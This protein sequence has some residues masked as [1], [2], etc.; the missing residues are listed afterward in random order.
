MVIAGVG[1]QGILSIAAVLGRAALG[2]GLRV[3][4]S[5]VH[6]MA[7][8]GGAVVS[9]FRIADA[10]IHSDVIPRGGA[11]MLLS[12]EPM[13][14]LRYTDWLAAGGRLI[15]DRT[16]VRNVAPYPEPEALYRAI[17]AVPG[18]IL[19]D[20]TALARAAGVPRGLN[21]AMLGAASSFVELQAEAL[22][23]S[24]AEQFAAKGDE[25]V[26]KNIDVFRAAREEAARHGGAGAQRAGRTD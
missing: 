14:A 10:P 17:R 19:L 15:S 4:Q 5:E 22:E 23:Q 8:R 2:R 7:Q 20:G 26:S 6:G 18:H 3:K 16:P 25:V 12:M 21:M 13:E 1:G 9:H 11:D 24:I